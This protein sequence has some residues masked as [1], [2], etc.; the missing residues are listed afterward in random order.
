M[1]IDPPAIWPSVVAFNK[2][3]HISCRD[4]ITIQIMAMK[5]RVHVADP[6]NKDRKRVGH[7][8][9]GPVVQQPSGNYKRPNEGGLNNHMPFM[10]SKKLPERASLCTVDKHS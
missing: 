10:L 9:L 4:D 5:C 7:T 6:K 2:H 3:F 1:P 8:H